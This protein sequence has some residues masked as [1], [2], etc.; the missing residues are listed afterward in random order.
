MGIFKVNVGDLNWDIGS[1]LKLGQHLQAS[2]SSVAAQRIRGIGD[3]T[4]LIEDKPGDKQG[5][6]D[7]ACLD[8]VGYPPVDDSICI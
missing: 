2:P 4:Q 1:F 6:V 8:D 7:K 3:V 5:A